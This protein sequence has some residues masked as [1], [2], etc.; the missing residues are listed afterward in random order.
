MTKL[1]FASEHEYNKILSDVML[2]TGYYNLDIWDEDFLTTGYHTVCVAEQRFPGVEIYI[3]GFDPLCKKTYTHY[4]LPEIL[5]RHRHLELEAKMLQ[6]K[7]ENKT[8]IPL[9]EI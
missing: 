5:P 3:V 1:D 9:M 4:W 6:A 7:I 2:T 8:I